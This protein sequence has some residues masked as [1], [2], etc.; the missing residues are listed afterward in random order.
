M[1]SLRYALYYGILHFLILQTSLKTTVII[2]KQ[3]FTAAPAEMRL[4]A[5]MV[6]NIHA[7]NLFHFYVIQH[8][9]ELIQ[10]FIFYTYFRPL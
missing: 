4:H 10:P 8:I 5:E 6:N 3:D 9:T 1:I 2:I 7:S